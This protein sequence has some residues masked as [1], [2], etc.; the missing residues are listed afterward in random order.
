[1]GDVLH[2]AVHGG[3]TEVWIPAR[4]LQERGRKEAGTAGDLE[5]Q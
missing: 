4:L 2:E 5:A 3:T 1:M